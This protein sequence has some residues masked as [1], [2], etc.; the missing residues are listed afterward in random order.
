MRTGLLALSICSLAL[1]GCDLVKMMM[2]RKATTPDEARQAIQSCEVSPDNIV[3]TVT[4]D[5]AF[6]FGRKFPGSQSL[7]PAQSDCLLAWAQHNRVEVR[8][9]GWESSAT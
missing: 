6:A 5:G 1:G 8:F 2:P 3:W 4:E 9:I 7:T